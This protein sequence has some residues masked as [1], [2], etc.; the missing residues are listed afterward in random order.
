MCESFDAQGILLS[1][2]G[3]VTGLLD[4]VLL[5]LVQLLVFVA[6]RIRLRFRTKNNQQ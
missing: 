1:D 5:C 3:P 6:G 2:L 4:C